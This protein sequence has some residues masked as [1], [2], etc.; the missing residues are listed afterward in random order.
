MPKIM[1]YVRAKREFQTHVEICSRLARV[2][3]AS[4]GIWAEV[5]KK[6]RIW[7]EKPNPTLLVGIKIQNLT[8]SVDTTF[9]PKA[10]LIV[11]A[12]KF[13][14]VRPALCARTESCSPDLQAALS[15]EQKAPV[16]VLKE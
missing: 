5:A 13:L 12:I 11:L 8:V 9:L 10:W 6:R 16:A 15:V 14:R 4:Q 3:K 2:G 7:T 1:L